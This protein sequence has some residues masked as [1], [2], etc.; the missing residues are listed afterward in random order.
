MKILRIFHQT[1]GLQ[2]GK[3][4]KVLCLMET[5]VGVM[6][7]LFSQSPASYRNNVATVT[8]QRAF[9]KNCLHATQSP[10]RYFRTRPRSRLSTL[11][12]GKPCKRAA[13]GHKRA[14]LYVKHY[15]MLI[16]SQRE[17]TFGPSN[18]P[19]LDKRL[20]SHQFWIVTY[21][22][23]RESAWLRNARWSS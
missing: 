6:A 11:M 7:R 5:Q 12:A 22:A 13:I 18:Q 8:E 3:K 9:K 23:R 14:K 15:S 4:R 17:F 1:S 20:S 19:A 10:K 21:P 2:Q 16:T